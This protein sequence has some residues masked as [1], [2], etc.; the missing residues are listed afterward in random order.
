M[1]DLNDGSVRTLA[2]LALSLCCISAL[3]CVW[4]L[5]ALQVPDSPFHFGVLSGPIVQLRN[6]SFA[7]GLGALLKRVMARRPTQG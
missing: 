7:L 5:F 1:A 4:E 6:F 2:R 3:A